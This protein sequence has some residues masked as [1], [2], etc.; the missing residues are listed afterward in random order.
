MI[1]TYCGKIII[2]IEEK[3]CTECMRIRSLDH[4]YVDRY[5]KD[6]TPSYRANCK[7]CVKR[8]SAQWRDEN[9]E[10]RNTI[11]LRYYRKIRLKALLHYSNGMLQCACC[12]EDKIEFLAI[13]HIKND[14]AEHRKKVGKTRAIFQWLQ[15]HDYPPG[16]QVLCHNCNFAKS[17]HGE[18]PH[19][20][21]MRGEYKV[22][23]IE[24]T[25]NPRSP[26]NRSRRRMITHDGKTMCLSDWG[27]ETGISRSAIQIRLDRLGWSVHDALTKPVRKRKKT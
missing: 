23:D 15:K 24:K 2:L 20:Q 18:C 25:L 22:V 5:K 10:R 26:R 12:G 11:A 3:E 17:V 13:D 4:F 14:G 1:S 27:K 16:F 8:R 21:E 7:E 9:R 19:K 6:G